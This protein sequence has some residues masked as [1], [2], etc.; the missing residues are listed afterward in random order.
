M[1]TKVVSIMAACFSIISFCAKPAEAT[2]MTI[3]IEA[4]VDD[5]Q[6]PDNYLNGRIQI[7]DVITGTYTYD[8]DTPDSNPSIYIGMYEHHTSPYGIKLTIGDF[9]FQSDPGNIDF[10]VSVGNAGGPYER[11]NYLIRSYNNLG[12]YD[13]VP[14]PIN[15]IMWQLDDESASAVSSDA[16]PVTPPMLD[17][18]ESVFGLRISADRMWGID[19]TVTSVEL[20][21]EPATLLLLSFGGTILARTRLRKR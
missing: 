12:L 4:V 11:D 3:A 6:D 15:H 20:I 13:D 8:T 17:D 18:W 16:L 7:G 10:L 21:P 9:V 1:K 19:A 5:V 14:I 2:L